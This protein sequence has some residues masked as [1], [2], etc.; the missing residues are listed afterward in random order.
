MDK[1]RGRKPSDDLQAIEN[2]FVQLGQTPTQI[3]RDLFPHDEKKQKTCQRRIHR[4]IKRFGWRDRAEGVRAATPEM[5]EKI[6]SVGQQLHDG[7]VSQYQYLLAQLI[8][9]RNRWQQTL[10]TAG[11]GDEK[12]TLELLPDFDEIDKMI[13]S[14]D[15]ITNSLGKLGYN[16]APPPLPPI[17]MTQVNVKGSDILA[18]DASKVPG[19]EEEKDRLVELF[20]RMVELPDL[21]PKEIATHASDGNSDD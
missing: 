13:V 20:K 14:L 7:L 6:K 1:A 9:H 4:Y 3:A 17:N 5:R 21:K 19:S 18:I 11:E 10:V 12:R 8:R 16:F 2:R 15:R